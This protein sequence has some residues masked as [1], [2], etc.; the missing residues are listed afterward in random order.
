MQSPM[1][2]T[3]TQEPTTTATITVTSYNHNPRNFQQILNPK[4]S[5]KK[6]KKNS[7]SSTKP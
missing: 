1:R 3:T 5:T 4:T 7:K 2:V 6:K